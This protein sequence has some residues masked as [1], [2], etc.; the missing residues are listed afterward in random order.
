MYLLPLD[1]WPRRVLPPCTLSSL[2]VS[3][4]TFAPKLLCTGSFLLHQ[5]TWDI[6]SRALTAHALDSSRRRHTLCHFRL[7]GYLYGTHQASGFE[8]CFGFITVF[9]RSFRP[10]LLTSLA[11]S[12]NLNTMQERVDTTLAYSRYVSHPTHP[13][14]LLNWE[15]NSV[16]GLVANHSSSA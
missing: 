11:S 5:F 7:I 6:G 15:V 9:V 8:L 3:R 13:S 1:G 14:A 10:K 16:Q 4:H 12:D 2:T